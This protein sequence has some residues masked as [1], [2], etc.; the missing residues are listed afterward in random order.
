MVYFFHLLQPLSQIPSLPSE[1]SG[2]G[3]MFDN[4]KNLPRAQYTWLRC[5]VALSN[6]NH[7]V[8]TYELGFCTNIPMTLFFVHIPFRPP[9]AFLLEC[10][11]PM[12][13]TL[14]AMALEELHPP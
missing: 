11:S 7:I 12:K 2:Q 1:V 13:P 3:H 14:L 10:L 9:L 4:V 6:W 5:V 8:V